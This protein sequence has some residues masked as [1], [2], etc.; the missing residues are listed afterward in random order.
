MTLGAS[1]RRTASM[2]HIAWF[3]ADSETR[4]TQAQIVP[5]SQQNEGIISWKAKSPMKDHL[6]DNQFVSI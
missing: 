2:H 3:L 6:S 5:P 4:A 1:M